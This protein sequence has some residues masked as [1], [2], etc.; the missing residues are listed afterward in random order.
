MS[1]KEWRPQRDSNPCLH[2]E[3][4]MSWASRRWGRRRGTRPITRPR[5]VY[6]LCGSR[7]TPTNI[8]DYI[9]YSKRR[10]AGG[11]SCVLDLDLHLLAPLPAVELQAPCDM[12]RG[13][14]AAEQGAAQFLA[15]GAECDR[16]QPPAVRPGQHAAH[17]VGADD[18]GHR[19][20]LRREDEARLRIACAE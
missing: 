1:G 5:L 20:A 16:L 13:A 11:E 10:S 8:L 4:V 9:S 18:I 12:Q 2:R 14:A 6:P 19:H 7:S 17:V 3:R 15:G